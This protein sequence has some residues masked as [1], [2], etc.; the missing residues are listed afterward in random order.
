M[1]ATAA[2]SSPAPATLPTRLLPRTAGQNSA[3]AAGAPSP[4]DSPR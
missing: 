3:A 1:V 2:S 4:S